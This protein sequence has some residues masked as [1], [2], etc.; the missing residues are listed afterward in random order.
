MNSA[1]TSMYK[2]TV[3]SAASLA[4]AAS[5]ASS[6]R[7]GAWME[8]SANQITL[9]D[10]P[11]LET[12]NQVRP[13]K[14][15]SQDTGDPSGSSA[16]SEDGD[17]VFVVDR[18]GSSRGRN[19]NPSVGNPNTTTM[20]PF[21][22]AGM[23]PERGR[24]RSHHP[25]STARNHQ[26]MVMVQN[27]RAPSPSVTSNSDV[28]DLDRDYI[29]LSDG[30][31]IPESQ[32]EQ[33]SETASVPMATD[34]STQALPVSVVLNEAH[35]YVRKAGSSVAGL[36]GSQ[37]SVNGNAETQRLPVI[38]AAADPRTKTDGGKTKEVAASRSASLHV[39]QLST[40]SKFTLCTYRYK[41]KSYKA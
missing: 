35:K 40:L 4:Q 41:T 21:V 1:L 37:Q 2:K 30:S 17:V 15:G 39:A 24:S 10:S 19:G 9:S 22:M 28:I 16:R 7:R 33:N 5:P 36:H 6:P 11:A 31:D 12:A 38:R 32:R 23:N 18:K 3:A 25:Q 14:S 20:L 8:Q 26:T 29:D 27:P 13:Q 34:S